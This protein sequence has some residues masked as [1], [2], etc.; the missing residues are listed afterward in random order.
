MLTA[1]L[2]TIVIAISHVRDEGKPI[3]QVQQFLVDLLKYND[4][5]SNNWSDAFYITSVIAALGSPFM[6]QSVKDQSELLGPYYEPLPEQALVHSAVD[7][8][9][10]Y[11]NLDRLVPSYHN[12]I[13]IAGI[14][15]RVKMMMASLIPLDMRFL[16]AYTREGNYGAVRSAAF[17]GLLLLRGLQEKI[18]ARYIFAVLRFDSNR[19][20]QRRLAQSLVENLP[21]LAA[22]DDLT[23]PENGHVEESALTSKKSEKDQVE[24]LLKALRTHVGRSI[25]L[26][27][28]MM[29]V[30]L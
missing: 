12:T 17:E 21:I 4:N 23:A 22:M 29:A 15:W 13:T 18:I 9:T 6:Q 10:R 30:L 16:L 2:Q 19:I 20:V 11:I 8:V 5:A 7:E 28:S 1:G 14:E 3:P 25:T 27:D 24:N 26:R